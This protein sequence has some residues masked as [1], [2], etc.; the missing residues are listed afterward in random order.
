MAAQAA[1][2]PAADDEKNR[3]VPRDHKENAQYETDTPPR[4]QAD[5]RPSAMGNRGG[6]LVIKGSFVR[7]GF[8]VTAHKVC[9][10]SLEDQP[11]KWLIKASQVDEMANGRAKGP[12][13]MREDQEK[14]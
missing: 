11:S 2:T 3:Q 5:G 9:S 4:K 1:D 8:F 10:V 6:S 13:P 12:A 14:K 7:K